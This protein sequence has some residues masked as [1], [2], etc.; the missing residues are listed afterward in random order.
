MNSRPSFWMARSSALDEASLVDRP[1]I[2]L[3][4]VGSVSDMRTSP[5]E[6]SSWVDVDDSTALRIS[7]CMPAALGVC[8]PCGV[9]DGV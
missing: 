5:S 6:S 7:T 9:L 2:G 4:R 1:G 8:M 3:G